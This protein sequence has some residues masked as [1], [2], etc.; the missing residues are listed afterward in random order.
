MSIV[1]HGVAAGKGIAI[2]HAHLITRGITEVPQ[3]DIDPRQT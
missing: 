1:L 3:Y 2:G